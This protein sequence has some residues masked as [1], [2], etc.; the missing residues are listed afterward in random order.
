M[1]V[2]EL[3]EYVVV[4]GFGQV[5]CMEV[6][7]IGVVQY[8]LIECL[9][10]EVD[11]WCDVGIEVWVFVYVYCCIQFQ[12]VGDWCYGFGEQCVGVVF[13]VEL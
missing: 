6:G 4:V 1:E 10:F 2:I 13:V 12:F 7:G 3:G 8:Q 9:V 11:F 5:W